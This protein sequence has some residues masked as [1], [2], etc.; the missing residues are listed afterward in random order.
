[1]ATDFSSFP[2]NGW[3]EDGSRS[4]GQDELYGGL[5]SVMVRVFAAA[6]RSTAVQTHRTLQA[7]GVQTARLAEVQH[8]DG[9]D[10]L[11][12]FAERSEFAT[13]CSRASLNVGTSV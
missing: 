2:L 7:A 10:Y 1:M 4:Y 5:P 8:V 6:E 13:F 9:K 12:V 11:H 3:R